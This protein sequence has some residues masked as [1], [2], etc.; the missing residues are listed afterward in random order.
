MTKAQSEA[1]AAVMQW[2]RAR[3]MKLVSRIRHVH[4]RAYVIGRA[5]PN[6]LVV[7]VPWM[8]AEPQ[9][10]AFTRDNGLTTFSDFDSSL[11]AGSWCITAYVRTATSGMRIAIAIPNG[12]V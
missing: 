5:S 4:P 8:D 6:C 11:K 3:Q 9:M 7:A 10:Q 2:C 12:V 1:R